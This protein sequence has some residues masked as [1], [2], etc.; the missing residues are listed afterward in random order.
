MAQTSEQANVEVLA[1]MFSH[2]DRETLA[3]VLEASDG[4]VERAIEQLLQDPGAG[5]GGGATAASEPSATTSAPDT[6]LDE[7]IARQLAR[8]FDAAEDAAMAAQ[9]QPLPSPPPPQEEQL[10]R[11]RAPP[12]E[13]AV[14]RPTPP[15]GPPTRGIR[16]TLPPDFLR[17]PGRRATPT[18]E[19]RE[20]IALDEQLAAAMQN[21]SF[22]RQ[23]ASDPE[24]ARMRAAR[25]QAGEGQGS[26][27]QTDF[28]DQALGAMSAMGTA[29]RRRL[30]SLAAQFN[31]TQQ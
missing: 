2:L 8:D 28:V 30:A 12:P 17:V 4:V 14:A 18:A 13:A 7:E 10:P 27:H 1:G 5:G 24:F 25:Q 31:L 23:L 6:T 20:Q 19:E 11:G 22:Q 15:P 3:V 26:G 21:E 29:A 9:Q 16:T